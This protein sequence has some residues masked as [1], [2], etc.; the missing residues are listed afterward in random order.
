MLVPRCDS[1]EVVVGAGVVVGSDCGTESG[2]V[3]GYSGCDGFRC[4][5][6]YSG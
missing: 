4:A 3:S 1:G 6:T 5:W 2:V